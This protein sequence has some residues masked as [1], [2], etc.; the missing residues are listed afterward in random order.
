[1]IAYASRTGTRRNLA[2]LRTAGWRL[3]V[4]ARGVLRDEGFRYALDNGAWTAHQ[5]GEPFDVA[6]FERAVDLMGYG[7]DFIVLPD[8]VAGGMDS[9][10]LSLSWMDRLREFRT[11]IPVQDGMSPRDVGDHVST[12][13]G[14][15]V[16][17]ST[18]WKLSTMEMWGRCAAEWRCWL[19]VGRVNSVKRVALCA[20]AG[21]T[22]FDGSSVT[23][24]AVTLPKLD[25]SRRQLDILSPVVSV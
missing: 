13:R 7:A 18:E 22:S 2:A 4:S 3:M 23:R 25:N 12:T 11:L 17:G 16:G 10:K 8:I 14:I 1:M 20:S 5:L 15:F 19:H 6:A 21:A 24:Y 9:L